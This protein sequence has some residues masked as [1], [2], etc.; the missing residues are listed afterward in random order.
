M[1]ERREPS[2]AQRAYGD[3]APEFVRLTDEVMFGQVW[4]RAESSPKSAA[5]PPSRV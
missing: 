2:G 1:S 3:F 5:W 4:P